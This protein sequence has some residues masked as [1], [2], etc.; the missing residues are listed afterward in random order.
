MKTSILAI[1]AVAAGLALADDI[2]LPDCANGCLNDGLQKAGC[3]RDNIKDCYCQK[4]DVN[5]LVTC[6]SN[7]CKSQNDLLAAAQSAGQICPNGVGNN[8][9]FGNIPGFPGNNNNNNNNNNGGGGQGG[10]QGGGNNGGNKG[11]N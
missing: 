7:N 1:L 3:T 11:G 6:V 2:K 4:A 9:Q 5:S 8:G 10:G